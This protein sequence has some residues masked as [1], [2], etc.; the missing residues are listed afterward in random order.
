MVEGSIREGDPVVVSRSQT[1]SKSRRS[2]SRSSRRSRSSTVWPTAS[3]Q[4][5][6][7]SRTT[8]AADLPQEV[9][10]VFGDSESVLK[11]SRHD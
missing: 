5:A 8:L 7:V 9:R 10:E 1:R 2:D 3:T 6:D 11:C 4:M